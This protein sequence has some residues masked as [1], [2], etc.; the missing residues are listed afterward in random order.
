MKDLFKNKPVSVEYHT[1]QDGFDVAIAFFKDDFDKSIY[2]VFVDADAMKHINALSLVGYHDTVDIEHNVIN[3]GAYNTLHTFNYLY[4]HNLTSYYGDIDHISMNR[5]DNT[6]LNLR[7]IPHKLNC[8]NKPSVGYLINKNG[9]FSVLGRGNISGNTYNN[10]FDAVCETGFIEK[11]FKKSFPEGEFLFDYMKWRSYDNDILL[12]YYR[13]S[14]SAEEAT[15]RHV[16]KHANNAWVYYRYNLQDYYRDNH[17]SVPD[18][19]LNKDGFMLKK[20]SE[21]DWL[22]ALVYKG[23]NCRYYKYYPSVYDYPESKAYQDMIERE[24][25]YNMLYPF[26]ALLKCT[27][28]FNNIFDYID[29]VENNQ[30]SLNVFNQYISQPTLLYYHWVH[31]QDICKDLDITELSILEFIGIYG[32]NWVKYAEHIFSKKKGCE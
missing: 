25:I 31:H 22:N 11:E 1:T 26:S 12:K 15:Y 16:M 7:N 27:E 4:T 3:L 6:S 19:S 30:E 23:F 8:L 32:S 29:A 21:T 10:E 13:G 20:G 14:I 28:F 2:P 9:S 24:V 5:L 17:I 18:F